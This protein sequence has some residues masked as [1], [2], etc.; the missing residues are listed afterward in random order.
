MG[1]PRVGQDKL[2]SSSEAPQTNSPHPSSGKS[3][4]KPA[5]RP[6]EVLGHPS[7]LVDQQRPLVVWGVGL[8]TAGDQALKERKRRRV[9]SLSHSPPNHQTI[10]LR[11]WR[12]SQNAQV[13]GPSQAI[14][15]IARFHGHPC[16]I[17]FQHFQ[18]T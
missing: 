15:F 13:E 14:W 6:G 9:H 1:R 7:E 11:G 12:F 2:S 18:T 10:N 16:K 3:I 17:K 5:G 4:D 8:Q